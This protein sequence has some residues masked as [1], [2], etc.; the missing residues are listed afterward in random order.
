MANHGLTDFQRKIAFGFDLKEATPTWKSQ[1]DCGGPSNQDTFE[2][3]ASLDGASFDFDTKKGFIPLDT[4]SNHDLENFR[5][6][7]KALGCKDVK[8]SKYTGK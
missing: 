6:I 2:Y 7:L 3:L 8:I 4:T 5:F 1:I